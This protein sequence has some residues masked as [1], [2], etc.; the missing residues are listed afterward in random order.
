M[1]VGVTA[2]RDL[3]QQRVFAAAEAARESAEERSGL[4][5]GWQVAEGAFDHLIRVLEQF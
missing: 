1:V 3:A 4:G 2:L 5:R